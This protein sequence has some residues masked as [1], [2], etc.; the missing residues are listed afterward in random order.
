MKM[1]EATFEKHMYGRTKT[2]KL[3]AL[4]DFA[5]RP[6]RHRGTATSLVPDLLEKVSGK[7]LCISL[8]L[9]PSTYHWSS[10]I[11]AETSFSMPDATQL[12]QTMQ[13]LKIAKE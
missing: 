1:S 6:V 9:D 3:S 5:H 13:E 4:G 10:N 11:P 2:R 7:E 12:K 8:L